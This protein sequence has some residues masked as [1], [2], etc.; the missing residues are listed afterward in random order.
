MSFS[1]ASN[2]SRGI[3]PLSGCPWKREYLTL[4]PNVHIDKGIVL[5]RKPYLD[6]YRILNIAVNRNGSRIFGALV[7]A[8]KK[9]DIAAIDPQTL[10]VLH[11][12]PTPFGLLPQA[13]F[14]APDGKG[15]WMT[16]WAR[17]RGD[18]AKKWAREVGAE[19]PVF[20]LD[21]QTGEVIA[22][23][24][25]PFAITKAITPLSDHLGAVGDY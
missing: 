6:V 2:T 1:F 19:W 17:F 4:T 5:K 16:P 21:D 10:M 9:I 14:P 20:R 8:D 12:T 3:I 13:F 24:Y 23:L 18:K 22:A 7:P 15:T 11:R 25:F